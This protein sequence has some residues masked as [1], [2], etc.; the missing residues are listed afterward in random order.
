M[1]VDKLHPE[2]I[3][4]AEVPSQE[5]K[6]QPAA[7]TAEIDLDMEK[8]AERKKAEREATGKGQKIDIEA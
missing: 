2:K 4:P 5:K 7:E 1:P 8:Q 3:A 6:I